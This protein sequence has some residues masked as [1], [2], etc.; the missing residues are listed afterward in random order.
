MQESLFSST[1]STNLAHTHNIRGSREAFPSLQ[2]ASKLLFRIAT[3]LFRRQRLASRAHDMVIMPPLG[4]R[5]LY[6]HKWYYQASDSAFKTPTPT[7]CARLDFIALYPIPVFPPPSQSLSPGKKMTDAM[8]MGAP[9]F[10]L[11]LLSK[12]PSIHFVLTH[13]FQYWARH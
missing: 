4:W 6:R 9:A 11:L 13:T 3:G 10:S 5:H 8:A 2:G 12:S 1:R 7:P